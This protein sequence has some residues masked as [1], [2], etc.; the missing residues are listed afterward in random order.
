[1]HPNIIFII[2]NY[3]LINAIPDNLKKYFEIK[4]LF[5]EKD[6]FKQIHHNLVI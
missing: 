1:M 6:K 5:N 3:I 2:Y 4:L